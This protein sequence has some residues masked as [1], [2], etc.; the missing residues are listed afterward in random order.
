LFEC[1]SIP[2]YSAI[3]SSPFI[4]FFLLRAYRSE[5]GAFSMS[6]RLAR[7]LWPRRRGAMSGWHIA[8]ILPNRPPP[9]PPAAPGAGFSACIEPA[10]ASDAFPLPFP[11]PGAAS[12]SACH[13]DRGA[14]TRSCAIPTDARFPSRVIPSEAQLSPPRHPERGRAAAESRDPLRSPEARRDRRGSHWMRGSLD[15]RPVAARSG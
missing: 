8:W 15:S 9:V 11:F 3:G 14:Q 13:S 2:Q 5:G 6:L 7:G 12:A 4:G 10:S 1:K